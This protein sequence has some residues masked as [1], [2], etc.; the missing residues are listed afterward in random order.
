MRSLI[1]A[2]ALLAATPAFAQQPNMVLLPRTLAE[3]AAQWVMQPDATTAVRLFAGLQACLAD[4]PANGRVQH[5][6]PDQCPA[7]TEALA[8]REK[9]LADARKAAEKH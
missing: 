5:T 2:A 1:L 3:A 8:E 7:V 6:G 4:N 9:E